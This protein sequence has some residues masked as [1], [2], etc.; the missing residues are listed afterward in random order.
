M[1][2]IKIYTRL[3]WRV[4]AHICRAFLNAFPWFL[5]AWAYDVF[6]PGLVTSNGCYRRLLKRSCVCPGIM[7]KMVRVG[8]EW[9]VGY[10]H[11]GQRCRGAW[12]PSLEPGQI[13]LPAR[14]RSPPS[15]AP[16]THQVSSSPRLTSQ[17]P[18]GQQH[19]NGFHCMSC[20][21]N[22]V[23]LLVTSLLAH[24]LEIM[25]GILV[26]S[27]CFDCG[28]KWNNQFIIKWTLR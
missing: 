4:E 18:C 27:D 17:A 16:L 19:R 26:P 3:D 20:R 21:S 9:G 28:P 6:P 25:S 24:Q 1:D 2:I 7:Y 8:E 15:P 10:T 12:T 5:L 14:R 11:D 22:R 13:P 23:A